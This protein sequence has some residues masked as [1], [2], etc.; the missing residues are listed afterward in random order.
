MVTVLY[1]REEVVVHVSNQLRWRGIVGGL[2][3]KPDCTSR[4]CLSVALVKPTM[5]VMHSLQQF[6][7]DERLVD[8]PKWVEILD[9]NSQL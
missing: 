7:E 9:E 3:A 2:Q 1:V 8:V 6:G 5:P 4:H